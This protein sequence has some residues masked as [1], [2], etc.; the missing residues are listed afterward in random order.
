VTEERRLVTVLFAD[1]TGS[2]ALGESIDPETLRGLLARY[3]A[4]GREVVESHGGTVEKFIGDALMAVFGLPVAHGDDADRALAAALELRDRVRDDPALG[5][6]LP[7][8]LGVNSG[9]VVASRDAGAGDFLVTGDAV[10]V[11]ARLQQTAEPWAIVVGERTASAARDPFAFR[12]LPGIAARGKSH[13]IGASE[14]LGRSARPQVRRTPMVGRG[15]DLAQLELVAGRAFTERRPFL[16]SVIAAPGVGK[17]RLLEESV[18]RLR[19]G[20][21]GVQVA[22]AQ[23]LPYGQRLTFWPMR[24][25]LLDLLELRDDLPPDALRRGIRQWLSKAGD[26][27]AERTA[28]LLAATIGAGEVE[29]ADRSALFAAWRSTIEL[30]ALGR[31]LVLVVEDLHWSSDSLLDLVEFILQPRGEMPLLMVALARPELLDRRPNWGGGRR[32]FVSL[33]LEPLGDDEVAELVRYLLDGAGPAV[34]SSIVARADGNPFY[35]GEIARSIIERVPDLRD[36]AAVE[37]GL[38]DLPDTVQATILARLDLLPSADRRLLQLGSVLGRTFRTAGV[39]ALEPELAALSGQLFDELVDRDLIRPAERDAY[40]FR[41]ILIREVAYGTLTRAERIRLHEAAGAWLDSTAGEDADALAELI[42][43]HYQEAISLAR[44]IDRPVDD[45]SRRRAVA[46]L[47]RA[48]SAAA[49]GSAMLEAGRHLRAAIELADPDQTPE[50]YLRLGRTHLGSDAGI[51]AFASAYEMGRARGRS[52]DFLLLALALRLTAMTRWF[53]SVAR[54]PSPEEFQKLVDEAEQLMDQA[55]DDRARATFHISQSFVPFWLENLGRPANPETLARA[56]DHAR[57]GLEIA[58][59]LDDAELMSA[60]LDGLGGVRVGMTDHAA[61]VE[62]AQ[63]RLTLEARLSL[64]ERLDAY[65]VLAWQSTLVGALDEAVVAA[66]RGLSAVQPGQ[67]PHFA[68]AVA[69]WLPYAL[70]LRGRWDEVPAATERC[71]QLWMEGGRA[72]AGYAL[73]GFIAALEVFRAR[74]DEAGIEACAEVV[75]EIV[76]QFRE[77]HPTRRLAGFLGPDTKALADSIATGWEFYIQRLQHVERAFA[78]CA[79][80]GQ[81]VPHDTVD[82]VIATSRRRAAR[83]LLGQ[84]LRVRGAQRGSADDLREALALFEAIG[85]VPYVARVEVELG[86]LV[87]DAALVDRGVGRLRDLGDI[88]QLGRIRVNGSARPPGIDPEVRP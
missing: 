87:D 4:I 49:A 5:E 13:P 34:V 20:R 39:V 24:T 33:T 75:A 57:R 28:D 12:S 36:D 88:G 52:A 63:R 73:T 79:D 25:L 45:G 67:D 26:E 2:T 21:P 50:L 55:T 8:R 27:A 47:G 37:A 42:A 40:E 65:N 54:Q 58:E 82:R 71:R 59:R 1:V 3:F 43:Y 56:E 15:A 51:A 18:E 62:I 14:L 10:N 80:R 48:A 84:A 38:A 41:H 29:L 72:T 32:N 81:A 22:I 7:I 53:A 78:I 85:A 16:V 68:L 74:E 11:A 66:S 69:N 83:P 9:E 19:T 35:A 30:A 6:R 17:T 70:A 61:S 46:W 64:Q 23:C 44:L 86:R 76:D 77:D 60:A 31:P